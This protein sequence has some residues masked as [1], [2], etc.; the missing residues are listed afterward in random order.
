MYWL[1]ILMAGILIYF[2]WHYAAKHG[3]LS[4][5]GETLKAV[6]KAIRKR[7][8]IAQSLY[9]AGALYVLLMLT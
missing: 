5:E 6:D 3:F 9:L 7:V 2:H 4:I 8:I 1:N